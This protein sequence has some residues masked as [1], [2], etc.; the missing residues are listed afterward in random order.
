MPEQGPKMPVVTAGTER[1]KPVGRGRR[2]AMMLST[3]PAARWCCGLRLHNG[4]SKPR[5][6]QH[7]QQTGNWAPHDERSLLN[8]IHKSPD[9]R[10]TDLQQNRRPAIRPCRPERTKR[11]PGEALNV[12]DVSSAPPS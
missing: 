8:H 2:R 11:S 10:T 4:Q 9:R 12:V 7:E 3:A 6:Q 1:M 5:K